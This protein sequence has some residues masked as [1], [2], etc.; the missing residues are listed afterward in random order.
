MGLT[1]LKH[2]ASRS[3]FVPAGAEPDQSVMADIAMGPRYHL[4]L[5]F[6][7][8]SSSSTIKHLRGQYLPSFS[9]R[10][11]LTEPTAS[12]DFENPRVVQ[13]VSPTGLAAT[14]S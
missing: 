11:S 5:Y 4:K 6:A 1:L 10:P 7:D 14:S 2:V 12:D 13:H 9:F 8:C 3:L